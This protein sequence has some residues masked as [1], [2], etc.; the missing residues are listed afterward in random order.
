MTEPGIMNDLK[1]ESSPSI[2]RSGS[3][4]NLNN[5]HKIKTQPEKLE[6]K[7]EEQLQDK[8]DSI[9]SDSDSGSDSDSEVDLLEYLN[10]V[11]FS[12]RNINFNVPDK[13]KHNSATK[14]KYEKRVSFDTIN[15]QYENDGFDDDSY[16]FGGNDYD[17][18]Y[19][20]LD[21]GRGRGKSRFSPSHSPL[22]SPSASPN[23]LATNQ[24]NSADLSR[25]LSNHFF[26][27]QYPTRPIIT[28]RGCTFTKF[29]K[30]FEDL[31]LDKLN[32]KENNY[33]TPILPSRVILVYLNGR[34]HTWV[35][36]DWIL[37]KFIENGDT[38]II[39]GAI[40][41]DFSHTRRRS[42][43]SSYD[44]MAPK[45]PRT[46]MIQRN[47]PEYIKVIAKNIMSYAMEVINPNV[48]AKVTIELALGKT[49]QVMKEMYKLYEPNLVSTGTKPNLKISAPLRSWLSSKL[50]D[51][52][53]KNFPLPVIITP[54]ANMSPFE[55]DLEQQVNSRYGSVERRN[56]VE[57]LEHKIENLTNLVKS[58]D[59]EKTDDSSIS[60]I[61][62]GDSYSSFD[63][64]V[65]AYENYEK[66][67]HFNLKNLSNQGYNREYFTGSL[68]LISD[69][70]ADFCR[71]IREIDPDFRGRGSKL[72]RAI[73]GSNSFGTS[74]YRTKSLLE[75]IEKTKSATA[76]P[77]QP[78][79]S[80]KELKKKLTEQQQKNN[81]PETNP[82][83]S[84]TAPDGSGT[85]SP[86]KQTLKFVNLEAPKSK[87]KGSDSKS[88]DTSKTED[89]KSKKS[90]D[91][92]KGKKNL[93]HLHKSFSY[94][95]DGTSSIRPKLEA[96]KSHP[97]IR[98]N[99]T[100]QENKDK[101]DK[102][103]KKKRSRF[104]RL[105]S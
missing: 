61:S 75:P 70:S 40:N 93:S 60:S 47:R 4:P 16:Y 78:K 26:K 89:S 103:H 50:T 30:Q 6:D 68:K 105:F 62:S 76:A 51:R 27:P 80:Y 28:H 14:A 90:K 15:L 91:K 86:P 58:E 95:A 79:L 10:K 87:S 19:D 63:E 72:A 38:V 67:V 100:E 29:H 57:D 82:S 59:K 3:S 55:K 21:Y 39:V 85:V 54:S 74:T 9:N 96:S 49:K 66:D 41:L 99:M 1:R 36:L 12:Y 94:E 42:Y 53:V 56:S 22:H 69:K 71:E 45:T 2:A 43:N 24:R 11:D 23:R 52:L 8:A 65:K 37:N 35:A 18:D 46:R 73:T 7:I 92:D 64:I 48:L 13:E 31:Y 83:I 25:I 33:L 77:D 34:K 5:I 81:K 20:D 102:K 88:P 44:N 17:N 104:W 101:K 32:N 97:D 84:V 98:T